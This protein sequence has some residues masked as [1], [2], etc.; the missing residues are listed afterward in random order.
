[1]QTSVAIVT[2]DANIVFHKLSCNFKLRSPLKD[3][4]SKCSADMPKFLI[5]YLLVSI[6]ANKEENCKTW[7]YKVDN[8]KLFAWERKLKYSRFFT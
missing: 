2:S 5:L 6:S 1:M 3:L 7:D 8:I 4:T